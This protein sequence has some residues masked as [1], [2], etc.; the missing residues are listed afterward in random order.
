[1]RVLMVDNY[2]S[3]TYNLVHLLEAEGAEVS[4]AAAARVSI[5]EARELAPD[6]SSS[7]PA[8]G[9]PRGRAARSSSSSGSPRSAAR[10]THSRPATALGSAAAVAVAVEAAPY[11][12]LDDEYRVVETSWAADAGVGPNRGESLFDHFAGS[13]PL[14]LPYLE[15]ARHAGRVVTFAQYFDGYVA[16]VRIVPGSSTLTVV[17]EQLC[18][19]DVMTMDGL[20]A[21]LRRALDVLRARED[22]L[23]REVV[24]NRL[25][26]VE[27]GR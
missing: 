1:M 19:L 6:R 26:V 8:R 27:G 18:I 23:H 7:P 3:F 14:F 20:H 15:E 17:W 4:C 25:R 16:E 11:V 12:V 24:R 13:R 10:L 21:S 22:A 9:A 5:E 2:D